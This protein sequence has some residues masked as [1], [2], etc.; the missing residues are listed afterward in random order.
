MSEG[1]IFNV[2]K[3]ITIYLAENNVNEF[4]TKDIENYCDLSVQALSRNI[5]NLVRWGFI[6]KT[7]IN[8]KNGRFT[9]YV[10]KA[11]AFTKVLKVL[12]NE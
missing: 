6:E 3:S 8:T 10:I 9:K 12:Y 7:T 11:D 5:N 2:L 1:G 4:T